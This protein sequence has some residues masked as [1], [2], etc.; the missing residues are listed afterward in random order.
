MGDT[1]VL[2]RK[3]T[4]YSFAMDFRVAVASD[5]DAVTETIMLAFRDDPIWGVA[6]TGRDGATAHIR[7][8]WE[9][10]VDGA[11]PHGTIHLGGDAATVA[12]WIPP[13]VPEMTP[14][15]HDELDGLMA[16]NLAPE[17]A[18]AFA[19]LWERFESAH[20]EAPP[21]M[22]LSL[23]ATH[24]DHRGRGIGQQLLAANL[25]DFDA[26]GLPAYLESTN[27]ANNHRYERAGFRP[28]GRFQAV[29]DDAPVTTM[30]RD[31]PD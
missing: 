16:A 31:V 11:L 20:P 5:R 1:S 6:L 18:R 13:G 12:V 14:E 22:Y 9:F 29:I 21:H 23:L 19:E 7:R 17:R 25:A 10:F 2:S 3:A 30:W 27:P 28:I 4:A 24:P 26:A 8:F 15:Q